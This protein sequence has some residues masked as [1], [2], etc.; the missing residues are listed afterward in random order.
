M[1]VWMSECICMTGCVLFFGCLDVYFFR[2]LD[3]VMSNWM[4]VWLSGCVHVC[5]SAADCL[6]VRKI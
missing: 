3:V 6:Y 4:P 2:F 5:L 1:S